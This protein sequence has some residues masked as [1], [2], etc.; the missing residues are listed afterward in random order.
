M[1]ED[2]REMRE[3]AVEASLGAEAA[4]REKIDHAVQTKGVSELGGFKKE[5][6]ALIQPRR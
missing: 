3:V 2:Q 6:V 5:E 4:R 1:A